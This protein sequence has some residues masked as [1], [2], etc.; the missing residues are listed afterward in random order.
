LLYTALYM[1]ATRTQIY[2][3][4]DQRTRLDALRRREGKP[5]AELVREAIDDYLA[6]AI[7][8]AR[9]ALDATFGSLPDLAVP[10]RDEWDRG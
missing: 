3:T 10:S 8:D 7:P 5:L 1:A 4:S 9:E 2:L 6:H